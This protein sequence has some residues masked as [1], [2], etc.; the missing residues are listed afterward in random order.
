MDHGKLV[1]GVARIACLIK[2]LQKQN[3]DSL[4]IDAGDIFQGTPMFT[5]YHGEVE[6]Q[7]LNKMGCNIYTIGNHEFDEG[8]ANLAKQL[9]LAKFDIISSNLDFSGEPDLAKLV[10]PSVVKTIKGERVAFIGVITPELPQIVI[11]L[12]PV[13]LKA[14]GND[15]IKPVAEEVERCKKQGIN[16]I[17]L[18]SHCGVE[19]DKQLAEAL[20]DVAVIIGGH[21]HTR[22]DKPIVVEHP[23]GHSTIIVQTGSYGHNLGK[24]DLAFNDDGS[25][26]V[27]DTSYRLFNITDRIQEDPELKAYIAEKAAPL[28]SLRE[29][30]DGFASRDFDNR[31]NNLAWDSAIGDLVCD[32]LVEAGHE[33]GA[34]IAF[35]NRGGIRRRIERGPI[36][37]EKVEE[38]LPFDNKLVLATVDGACLLRIL[39]HSLGGP[40]MGNF[41]DV[42]GL[43]VAY[44]PAKPAGQ[45]IVFALARNSDGK[46]EPIS[47][48]VQYKIATNDF[49]F[50]GGPGY[51]FSCAHD[52]KFH[53]ER[54]SDD[55]KKYLIEKRKI[56]P[57]PPSRIV[58]LTSGILELVSENGKV[59]L[60]VAGTAPHSQL[61]LIEGTGRGITPESE[62]CPVPLTNPSMID[63][64]KSDRSG[65]YT[66]ILPLKTS[67]KQNGKFAC[68]VVNPPPR[69]TQKRTVITYPVELPN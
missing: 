69:A 3:N 15:W 39:E 58:P 45:R 18:V 50:K 26:N 29:E 42:H 14:G 23:N 64:E 24:L 20:P 30:V 48:N 32:A 2:Q 7:A 38:M 36:T 1:G 53:S 9:S 57:E 68:V 51:D 46:F 22:L 44:D 10:K 4:V 60:R 19:P 11:K 55:F 5:K 27:T 54:L 35:E 41:L 49:V 31:F 34:Q 28:L 40:L 65:N 59:C 21:S 17:I 37:L 66:W 33:Y 43:K 67:A 62:Y 56:Q 16:K 12:E 63:T 52:V 61:T 8:S 13:K 47:K 25:L 6:V